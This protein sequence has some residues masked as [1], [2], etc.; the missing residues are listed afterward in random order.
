MLI[1]APPLFHSLPEP[2]A[3]L[4]KK[5]AEEQSGSAGD[6]DFLLVDST[7]GSTTWAGRASAMRRIDDSDGRKHQLAAP[8]FA[9]P[10]QIREAETEEIA[11]SRRLLSNPYGGQQQQYQ[12]QSPTTD[13][14]SIRGG[15]LLEVRHNRVAMRITRRQARPQIE[16]AF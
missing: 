5:R 1:L 4:N 16:F 3:L 14:D 11:P 7:S 2:P 6:D 10:G 9:V 12:R 8:D 15:R 13:E